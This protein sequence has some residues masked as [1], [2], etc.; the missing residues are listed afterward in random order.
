MDAAV[1]P[2]PADAAR[3]DA[4]PAG[5]ASWTVVRGDR[6]GAIARQAYGSAHYA[7][8]IAAVN[9]V[10]PERLAVGAVLALPAL[11]H[12]VQGAI[13]PRAAA[14]VAGVAGWSSA[15]AAAWAS[16]QDERDLA[17]APLASI[18]QAADDLRQ[19]AAAL[20]RGAAATGFRRAAAAMDVVAAGAA[21]ANGYDVDTVDRRLAEGIAA[22]L[23]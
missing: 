5:L 2:A 16:R 14:L 3:I 21:P 17:G 20:P 8:V 11:D 6:L 13:E 10:A 18:R 9:H 19:G 4:A 15:R 22:L 12:V 1:A 7:A 23:R